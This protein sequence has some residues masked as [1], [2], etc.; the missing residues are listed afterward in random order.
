MMLSVKTLI[1]A[2]AMASMFAAKILLKIY[3][4]A[5]YKQKEDYQEVNRLEGRLGSTF[6]TTQEH[7]SQSYI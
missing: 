7:K 2:M 3:Y 5:F 6:R 1:V 4:F